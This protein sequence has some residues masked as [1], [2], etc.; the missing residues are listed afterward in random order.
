MGNLRFLSYLKCQGTGG[1][2]MFFFMGLFNKLTYMELILS[3]IVNKYF[4]WYSWCKC[5]KNC[6]CIN[7]LLSLYHLQITWI[8]SASTMSYVIEINNII[9]YWSFIRLYDIFLNWAI[10]KLMPL[11]VLYASF[12][13]IDLPSSSWEVYSRLTPTLRIGHFSNLSHKM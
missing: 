4:D 3:N 13:K 12:V 11:Q 5:E 6:T 2:L 10:C 7:I 8:N 1:L 9:R